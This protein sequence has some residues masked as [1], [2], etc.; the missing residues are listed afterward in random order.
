MSNQ[1]PG[2]AMDDNFS[3][4][5]FFSSPELDVN[6]GEAQRQLARYSRI[7][8]RDTFVALADLS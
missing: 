2:H 1:D 3:L 5:N 8:L 4:T 7:V 6:D